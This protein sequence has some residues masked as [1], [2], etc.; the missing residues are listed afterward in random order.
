[1]PDFLLCSKAEL[2]LRSSS[3]N[4]RIIWVV[5]K[6]F[7][8]RP[9]HGTPG[10]HLQDPLRG[11]VEANHTSAR[12]QDKHA[13][14]HLPKGHLVSEGDRIKDVKTEPH[15]SIHK[16]KNCYREHFDKKRGMAIE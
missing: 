13:R 7:P 15:N 14:L 16:E 1:M 8:D 6:Q 4:H 11:R 10:G 3:V 2:Y 5:R 9:V 12:I